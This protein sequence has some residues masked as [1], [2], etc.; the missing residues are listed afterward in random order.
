MEKQ[1]SLRHSATQMSSNCVACTSPLPISEIIKILIWTDQDASKWLH[2]PTSFTIQF[3]QLCYNCFEFALDEIQRASIK[4]QSADPLSQ[5]NTT[6]KN[7]NLLNHSLLLYAIYNEACLLTALH[8]IASSADH[9][10]P[11][12]E[13]NTARNSFKHGPPAIVKIMDTQQ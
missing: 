10:Q 7:K 3:A 13:T 2:G 11:F 8:A 5:L 1:T 12:P 6:K 4:H 9:P